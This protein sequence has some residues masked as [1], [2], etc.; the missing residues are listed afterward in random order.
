MKIILN[1]ILFENEDEI[2]TLVDIISMSPNAPR[3]ERYKNILKQKY[4]F[5]Y[6]KHYQ[7]NDESIIKKAS[8]DDIKEKE[9]FFIFRKI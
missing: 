3:M 9:D 5:D 1:R 7:D 4:N 2:Q 6:D 8:L